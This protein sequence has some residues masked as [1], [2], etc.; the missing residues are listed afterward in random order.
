IPWNAWINDFPLPGAFTNEIAGKVNRKIPQ[1]QLLLSI[2]LLNGNRDELAFDFDGSLPD[3]NDLDDLQI[4]QAYFK[5][6]NFLVDQFEPDY[7][8]LAIEV[9]E[10]LLRSPQKWEGYKRLM[11]E[12]TSKIKMDYP[13]LMIAESVSLHNY[14]EPDIADPQTFV[15]EISDH[16][17]QND[18]IAIS[19]YPFFKNLK[20]A[21][22]IQQALDFL[23]ANVTQPIA[24]VETAQLAENLVVPNLNLSIDGDADSQ[25]LYLQTLIDNA[26]RRDYEFIVWWAHRDYDAL[27]ETFPEEVKDIGQLWRD[28]GLFTENGSQR[29]AFTTWITN[30]SQ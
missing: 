20:S 22:D 12:V 30:F 5:H 7:L 16:V 26:A 18:F 6:V 8:V 11:S 17:N 29:L 19:F 10:L 9:N 3:Y 28:T 2:S 14:Y 24:F 4:K 27:W 21:N 25:D 13:G 15:D 1:Q 23:H